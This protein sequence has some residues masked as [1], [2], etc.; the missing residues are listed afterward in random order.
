V[1]RLLILEQLPLTDANAIPLLSALSN[2]PSVL[3]N[4]L[5]T[6]SGAKCPSLTFLIRKFSAAAYTVKD[7]DLVSKP[8]PNA[9]SVP[10]ILTV[11]TTTH[12]E[13]ASS[14]GSTIS[15]TINVAPTNCSTD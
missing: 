9:N 7:C 5:A 6:F 4:A 1:G 12:A 13:A 14:N 11:T 2:E 3:G 15:Q 10:L 8:V